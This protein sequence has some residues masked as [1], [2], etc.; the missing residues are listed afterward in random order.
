MGL[1]EEDLEEKYVLGKG[2]GGQKVNK[3]H[4][5]VQLVHLPSSIRVECHRER[6]RSLNRYHARKLLLDELERDEKGGETDEEK[7]KR[8][9]IKKQKQR[10]KRRSSSKLDEHN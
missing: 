5:A 6:E 10:R 1:L 4:N 9:K 8:E 2:K 3:T 7:K